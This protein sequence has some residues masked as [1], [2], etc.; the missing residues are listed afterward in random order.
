M[1]SSELNVDISENNNVIE[2]IEEN[3]SPATKAFIAQTKSAAEFT[4]YRSKFEEIISKGSAETQNQEY[5]ESLKTNFTGFDLYR[6][7]FV[8]FCYCYEYLFVCDVHFKQSCH[9]KGYELQ[10]EGSKNIYY[11]L[12]CS[13][14]YG[15]GS[16]RR[17]LWNAFVPEE[18]FNLSGSGNCCGSAGVFCGAY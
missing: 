10:R 16:R 12:I 13:S 18:K 9:E 7:Q 3:P 14:A 1:S 11:A 2:A 8:L 6:T 15:S 17:I 5:V 4:Y